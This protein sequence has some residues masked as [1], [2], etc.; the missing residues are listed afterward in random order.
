MIAAYDD[1]APTDQGA[2]YW[3][4]AVFRLAKPSKTWFSIQVP[5]LCTVR[6]PVISCGYPGD[7]KSVS[8]FQLCTKCSMTSS[9]NFCD[10]ARDVINT[11]TPCFTAVGHSGGAIRFQSSP[12]VVRGTLSRGTD[13]WDMWS[14]FDQ[15]HYAFLFSTTTPRTLWAETCEWVKK[16]ESV[17]VDKACVGRQFQSWK[18]LHNAIPAVPELHTVVANMSLVLL[19]SMICHSKL[20]FLHCKLHLG[21]F[22]NYLSDRGQF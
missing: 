8:G 12:L 7:P 1:N 19:H 6:E 11:G 21:L 14:P 5:T 2:A 16:G 10:A 3:D 22:V 9:T 15:A 18:D 13:E 17:D 4:M 20:F